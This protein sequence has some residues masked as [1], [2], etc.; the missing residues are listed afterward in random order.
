MDGLSIVIITYN[1][2]GHLDAC[3]EAA[4]RWTD[5]VIVIDN[6]STDSTLA[7]TARWPVRVVANSS[8]RGFGAAANQGFAASA[9][10]HVLLLNPDVTLGP[11]RDELL[12]AAQ[13][14]ACG[15][16]VDAEGSIQAGFSVRRLPR[17]I[18]LALEVLGINRMWPGNPA[19]RRWRCL[20]LDLKI[21]QFVEQPAGAMLV[22]RRETWQGVG[23]F[24]EGFWPIWF[25]DV[26]FCH[27][28]RDRGQRIRLVPAAVAVHAGGHSI[29]AMDWR[30]RELF[31]YRSLWRYAIRRFKPLE[32]ALL[33]VAMT[34]GLALRAIQ[35]SVARRS[36]SSLGMYATVTASAFRG[37]GKLGREAES[38]QSE[39]PSDSCV[40]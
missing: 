32:R 24:D 27:S 20:D 31:W 40:K 28:L 18:D 36:I 2:A 8:N 21:P 7:V 10:Q 5:D 15:L 30:D 12:A 25:E 37:T 35:A 38:G 3:L 1:S 26:D 19:N 13:P 39:P 23:G 29:K 22:V 11:G 14:A 6:A 34:I 9:R 17:P 33:G 16:L 4:L